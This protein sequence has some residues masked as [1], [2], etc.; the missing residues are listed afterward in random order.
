MVE[1]FEH[2]EGTPF[3][4]VFGFQAYRARQAAEIASVYIALRQ[5]FPGVF[6]DKLNSIFRRSTRRCCAV[7]TC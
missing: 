2:R 5:R 4:Q 6:T 3:F 7:A 1:R